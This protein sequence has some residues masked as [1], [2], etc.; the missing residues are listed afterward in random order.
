M[1]SSEF[2][3]TEQ[4]EEITQADG[5]Q[6]VNDLQKYIPDIDNKIPGWLNDFKNEY[7]KQTGVT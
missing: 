3:T 4:L 6:M 1:K 2:L 7:D 5:Q